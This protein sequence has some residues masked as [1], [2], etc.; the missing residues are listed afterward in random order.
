MADR[1]EQIDQ[2]LA[3]TDREGY[4]RALRDAIAILQSKLTETN[5][6]DVPKKEVTPAPIAPRGR[7]RPAKAI[8]LVRDLI[9]AQPGL[10]GVEVFRTLEA[11][12]TPV[13]ERTVRSFLRR[14]RDGKI[15]WQRKDRWYPRPSERGTVENRSVETTH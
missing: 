10:K 9:L 8:A 3:D 2:L 6:A 12:G 14:L 15:I 1:R 5:V 11:Q 7:G 13:I 4:A